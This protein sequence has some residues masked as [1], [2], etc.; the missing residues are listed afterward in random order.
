M[1]GGWSSAAKG[2][3]RRPAGWGRRLGV[4]PHRPEQW[5]TDDWAAAYGAGQLAYYAA[6]DELARYSV[7]IGY[8]SWVDSMCPS[9][10]PAILDVGCG[11]GLLR[12]RLGDSAFSSYV[13][14]DV[15]ETA[16]AGARAAGHDRSRFV[17]GD[18][19]ELDLGR[20][21]VVVLN[22]VLYYAPDAGVLLRRLAGALDPGGLLVTSMWRH[23][24][25]R[26]L[27]RQVDEVLPRVDRV[28]VR[29]RGNRVNP[30]GWW[31]AANGSAGV[32]APAGAGGGR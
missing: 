12:E 1:S 11:T 4:L 20:F 10:A 17:V 24:G 28:E 13:G 2:L 19:A 16:V 9:R 14:V 3:A 6:L 15:S 30:R 31:I 22:E 21:D 29:N 8:I 27:W 26:A 18:A 23:P 5:S 32:G 25:D 7:I